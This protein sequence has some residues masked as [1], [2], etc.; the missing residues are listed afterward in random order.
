MNNKVLSGRHVTL[1]ICQTHTMSAGF[2]GVMICQPAP[3]HVSTH[4]HNP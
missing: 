1:Q 3:A 2:F 4:D